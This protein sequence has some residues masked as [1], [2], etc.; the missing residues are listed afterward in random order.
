MAANEESRLAPPIR[1]SAGLLFVRHA[2][3]LGRTLSR[4]D[5]LFILRSSMSFSR[6]Q[7]FCF[8]SANLDS[9]SDCSREDAPALTRAHEGQGGGALDRNWH[10]VRFV[11]ILFGSC[12]RC[13]AVAA[14]QGRSLNRAECLGDN[15][16][17]VNH[18]EESCRCIGKPTSFRFRSRCLGKRALV[19]TESSRDSDCTPCH[20][21]WEMVL[22]HHVHRYRLF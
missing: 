4:A 2:T 8:C 21:C 22:T 5:E 16:L 6:T 10:F 19:E 3:L 14:L 20:V 11:S 7:W 17:S 13:W 12:G 15:L 18:C 1:P 9:R